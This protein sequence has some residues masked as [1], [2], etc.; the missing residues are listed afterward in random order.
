MRAS[1]PLL[2]LP[3]V[4]AAAVACTH[5]PEDP[6]SHGDGPFVTLGGT[7]DK[8]TLTPTDGVGII[9]TEAALSDDLKAAGVK[10]RFRAFVED[11]PNLCSTGAGRQNAT[12]F[13]IDALS[14]NPS[15]APGTYTQKQ[16]SVPGQVDVSIT[17]LNGTCTSDQQDYG[18]ESGTV[19]ITSVS[20]TVVTG[21]FEMTLLHGDGT[22]SG[23]FNV[24]LC[25]GLK[26]GGCDP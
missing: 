11:R 15:F 17:K 3:L 16:D 6:I 1:T 13:A 2:A 21:N 7:F 19:T 24:P 14:D 8:L 20:A 26:L 22:L 9:D 10:S 23:S 4:F 12:V 18:A 25:P 5:D